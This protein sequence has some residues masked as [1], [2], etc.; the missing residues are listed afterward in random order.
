VK[1]QSAHKNRVGCGE[2]EEKARVPNPVRGEFDY[3]SLMK[4]KKHFF[5]F[6]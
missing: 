2:E 5:P 6:F 4:A 1:L 3:I